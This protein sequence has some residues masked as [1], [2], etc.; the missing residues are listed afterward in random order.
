MRRAVLFALSTAILLAAGNVSQA[1]HKTSADLRSQVETLADS[2]ALP[3]ETD[4]PD[5]PTPCPLAPLPAGAQRR[6]VS[7]GPRLA[8]PVATLRR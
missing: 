7:A 2:S 6:A 8:T 1:E 3:A 5:G 4:P